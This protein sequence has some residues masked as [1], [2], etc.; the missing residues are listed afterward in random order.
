MLI[1]SGGYGLV[2]A[3][4]SIGRYNRR[5]SLRDWPPQL[6]EECLAA[7][8]E[9]LRVQKVVAFCAR[10]T[11]YAELIRRTPWS[12]DGIYVWLASPDM[13]GR[14]GAQ[15]LVPQACG[16]AIGAFLNGELADRWVSTGGVP[17][18]VEHVG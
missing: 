5:F 2:L 16:Q 1:V 14:R 7:A 3:D 8:S 15:V 17:V 10:T 11:E 13:A 12:K 6:L 9:A 18:R 4:E